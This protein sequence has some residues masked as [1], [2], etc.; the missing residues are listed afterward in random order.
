VY[1][2]YVHVE[3]KAEGQ[4]KELKPLLPGEKKAS[5]YAI[6]TS[7]SQLDVIY[8]T[9]KG[10][11][12][13]LKPSFTISAAG[14]DRLDSTGFIVPPA[15]RSRAC[16]V[17][18]PVNFNAINLVTSEQKAGNFL[19]WDLSVAGPAGSVSWIDGILTNSSRKGSFTI[20]IPG[21]YTLEQGSLDFEFD[22][23][24]VTKSISSGIFSGIMPAAGMSAY[25]SFDLGDL[26]L[27]Y[28][29][30]WGED[31]YRAGLNFPVGGG[32]FASVEVPEPGTWALFIVGFGFVGLR[33]RGQRGLLRVCSSR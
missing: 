10:G 17:S 23:G 22:N 32:T 24:I 4:P 14:C 33:L 29:F 27:N 5:A 8:E 26:E 13:E 12:I 30:G 15:L 7:Q 11:K 2:A 6:A 28:D 19:S 21:I 31:L 9:K 20:D 16:G 3:G 25:G 18:D 1:S